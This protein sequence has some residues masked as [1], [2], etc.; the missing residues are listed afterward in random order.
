[1][2]AQVIP[3]DDLCRR[4][5]EWIESAVYTM[6][7]RDK[8][9]KPRRVTHQEKRPPWAHPTESDAAA[10]K[11]FFRPFNV[12]YPSAPLPPSKAQ[13]ANI[14]ASS[15]KFWKRKPEVNQAPVKTSIF[16]K[17][18]KSQ[19]EAGISRHDFIRRVET[20]KEASSGPRKPFCA[21]N[22]KAASTNDLSRIDLPTWQRS[23]FKRGPDQMNGA[24]SWSN[25]SL[26]NIG[27][28]EAQPSQNVQGPYK[29]PATLASLRQEISAE[30]SASHYIK[31]AA[32]PLLSIC[33]FEQGHA[34][35][36]PRYSN[37]KI[38][39]SNSISSNSPMARA[40]TDDPT[41][42]KQAAS[43]KDQETEDDRVLHD[44]NS[45]RKN[46]F[47]GSITLSYS[48]S[49][50]FSPGLAPT[51][52]KCDVMPHYHLCQSDTPT[53][54]D[55]GELID[56]PTRL[57]SQ[58]QRIQVHDD[59]HIGISD[60]HRMENNSTAALYDTA[61][62]GFSGYNL[63]EPD[64]GSTSTLK[65]LP[66]NAYASSAKPLSYDSRSRHDQIHS[67]N[68]GSEH[69]MTALE[70]LIDDLGYLGHLIT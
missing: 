60:L 40:F 28:G 12:K 51:N 23:G 6:D 62:D 46:S 13:E 30:A 66:S 44:R 33:F 25:T 24:R 14:P 31:P 55:D 5:W 50:N 16:A 15:W 48:T 65:K 45:P 4:E 17:F 70:T 43:V 64:Q 10:V 9:L 37:D 41:H 57:I 56:D 61:Y 22:Y 2:P 68:D 63:P 11:D 59:D 36:Q 38:E 26:V 67:W 27:S 7:P 39:T 18:Q 52:S 69:R 3:L 47:A 19:S 58:M 49:E 21:P 32:K 29:T 54:E 34:E 8:F 42:I 53:S 35:S 20:S 1:M